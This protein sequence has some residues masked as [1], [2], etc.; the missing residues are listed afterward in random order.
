MQAD[1]DQVNAKSKKSNSAKPAKH[2]TPATS[3]SPDKP[4]LMGSV[5]GLLVVVG[6]AS[7]IALRSHR[8]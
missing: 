6:G 3:E 1:G 2:Q 8:Y 7:W 5:A 4:V